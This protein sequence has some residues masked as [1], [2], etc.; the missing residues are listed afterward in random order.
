MKLRSSTYRILFLAVVL[1]ANAAASAA[2]ASAGALTIHKSVLRGTD[3]VRS[4]GF[5][6]EVAVSGNTAVVSAT[7]ANGGLG[8]AYVFVR[9]RGRWTQQAKL[10][11]SDSMAGDGF[12]S[13]V[14]ISG[15]TVVVGAPLRDGYRGAVYVFVRSGATWTQQQILTASDSDPND[16]NF[17]QSVAVSG[18]TIVVGAPYHGYP[19]NGDAYVFGSDGAGWTQQAEFHASTAG[20]V[21]FGTSVA[22]SGS[23][24]AVGEPLVNAERG[25]PSGVVFVYTRSGGAW[26][27]K[28]EL[29]P[30]DAATGF[31]GRSLALAGGTLVVGADLT[32]TEF[33]APGAAYV[34]TRSSGTWLEQQELAASDGADGAY[35]GYSVA[36]SR[37]MVVV[38]AG[39]AHAAYLFA[40]SQ[41]SWVQRRRWTGSTGVSV[42]ASGST[43]VLSASNHALAFRIG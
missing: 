18:L 6:G 10:T 22:V 2:P 33:D 43:A 34:Y 26:P 12:A 8:A 7:G 23:T 40:H 20:N 17:G 11:G 14:A 32:G 28:Q 3:T 39:N 4:D 29:D 1:V 19:G 36:V 41:S 25:G 38:G 31:L 16:D 24:V 13:A 21:E 5:G 42:A 30:P 37:T 35:F 9:S 27:L 15:T